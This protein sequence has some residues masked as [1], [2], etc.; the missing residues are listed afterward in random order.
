MLS[1]VVP[2]SELLVSVSWFKDMGQLSGPVWDQEGQTSPMMKKTTPFTCT[3]A[4]SFSQPL[5]RTLFHFISTL[6]ISSPSSFS[7]DST[8]LSP[9]SAYPHTPPPPPPAPPPSDRFHYH[10]SHGSPALLLMD[11][12]TRILIY[13]SIN[14]ITPYSTLT[15]PP[16][17]P[18]STCSTL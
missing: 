18:C 10:V 9:P 4:G 16:P 5:M 7:I 3:A 6:L 14:N 17:C 15:S 1:T 12:L 11:D 8:F 13:C 2:P